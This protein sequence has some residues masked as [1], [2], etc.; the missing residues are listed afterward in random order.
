M[1]ERVYNGLQAIS[2][3]SVRQLLVRWLTGLDAVSRILFSEQE[4]GH[5]PHPSHQDRAASRR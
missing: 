4:P 5:K 2:P 1:R 3:S